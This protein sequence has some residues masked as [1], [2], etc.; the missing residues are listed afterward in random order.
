MSPGI[1]LRIAG[2]CTNSS[3]ILINATGANSGTLFRLINPLLLDGIGQLRLNAFP[4]NLNSAYITDNGG[5]QTLTNGVSHSILGVGAVYGNLTNNGVVIADVGGARLDLNGSTK[6]NNGAFRAQAGAELLITSTTVNQIPAATIAADAGLVSICNSTI[7]GG[8][9]EAVNGGEVRN[10]C[11]SHYASAGIEGP[12]VMEFGAEARLITQL[13]LDGTFTV[14]RSAV[15]SGTLVRALT[16]VDLIG[17]GQL[18]LNAN[19]GNLDSAFIQDNGGGQVFSNLGPTIRG[20]GRIYPNFVNTALVTADASGRTLSLYGAT[21]TNSGV[22]RAENGGTLDIRATTLNQTG[23]GE[24]RALGGDVTICGA[25][26]TGGRLIAMPGFRLQQ[27]CTSHFGGVQMEG[28]FTLAPGNEMRLTSSIS[29]QGV[30]T[31][32]STGA[33]S[34]T[35]VRSLSSLTLSGGGVVELNAHPSNLDSAYLFDNGGGQVFTNADNTIRGTGRIYSNF[36]NDGLVDAHLAG[37]TLD[38][39]GS[40]K[41]N[42]SLMRSTNGGNLGVS[43]C[44]LNQL[45]G[46]GELLASDASVTISG[47]TIRGG[48]VRSTGPTG[49]VT[50]AS[51]THFQEG[52]TF[53]GEMRITPGIELRLATPDA[54]TNNGQIVL[55]TSGLNSGTLI[56]ALSDTTFAGNGVLLLNAYPG[57]LDSAYLFDNG[58]GQTTTNGPGHTI[59]GCGTIHSNFVNNGRVLADQTGRTL[60]LNGSTK[61]NNNLMKAMAGGTL[62]MN[63]LTLNQSA[64]GL[65]EAES[66]SSVVLCNSF[67]TG[68]ILRAL[69]GGLWDATCTN[70]MNAVTLEGDGRVAQGNELRLIGGITNHGRIV[71]NTAGANAA[72]QV[73]ALNALTLSGSGTLVLNAFPGNLDTAYLSDNGGGQVITNGPGHEIAGLGR[74]QATVVN[75]G[76]LAPGDGPAAVGSL[77]PRRQ[78]TCTPTSEIRIDVTGPGNSSSNFDTISSN[79]PMTIDGT[80]YARATGYT[81][82]LGE[83]F[84]IITGSLRT[85]IFAVTDTKGFR[86]DYLPN[87]VRLTA[88]CEPDLNEDGN[89][90]QDDVLYLINVIGGGDNPTGIDPDFN[91]DG[92][93]DQDDVGALIN[94]VAGGGC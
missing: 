26:V 32:N 58:G 62:L 38:L 82:G 34:G 70:H 69:P 51:T 63:G 10:T 31:V 45:T 25:T 33:N 24:V 78:L 87:G 80:L 42:R 41:V 60:R 1:E 17:S 35:L 59:R 12:F 90:D 64:S 52:V 66:G 92:N 85:G 4:G 8:T 3:T 11:T 9:I 20:S 37:R 47:S 44:T 13:A 61:T 76:I 21:K 67:V 79:S 29:N 19:G 77:Q 86:V 15:N 74:F 72:T 18:I 88:I 84:D 65:V 36:E 2:S 5:G 83:T 71:L 56:R 14:N 54:L 93:V 7:S 81:P 50:I 27:V 23:A 94:A 6:N 49:L 89:V 30:I 75:Q 22:L 53:S 73:R 16:N 68:G 28:A 55:N 91:R 39:N 43:A 46:P 57:N 48:L 40:T